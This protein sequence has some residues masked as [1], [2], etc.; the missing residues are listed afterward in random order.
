MILV[1]ER[2]T[3]A[4]LAKAVKE[5]TQLIEDWFVANPKRRVCNAE[6]WYGKRHKIK[7]RDVGSQ[8]QKI[9]DHTEVKGTRKST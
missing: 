1:Y 2:I 9:A 4:E 7:R 6:L 8:L 5:T 3:A